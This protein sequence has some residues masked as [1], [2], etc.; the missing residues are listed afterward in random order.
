MLCLFYGKEAFTSNYDFP[1]MQQPISKHGLN[2]GNGELS[3]FMLIDSEIEVT[4]IE[5]AQTGNP[6]MAEP[7]KTA[8]H[9]DFHEIF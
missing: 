3:P 8:F 9:R 7:D 6:I 2:S 1:W 4:A 5:G